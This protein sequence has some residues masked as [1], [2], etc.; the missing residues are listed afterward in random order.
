M[1]PLPETYD[2]IAL[3]ADAPE[4]DDGSCAW[5]AA[6]PC[7]VDCRPPVTGRSYARSRERLE[8]GDPES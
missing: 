6:Y 7:T 8:N 2:Y 1:T 3:G 5:C 4:P